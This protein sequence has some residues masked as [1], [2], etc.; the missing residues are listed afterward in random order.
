MFTRSCI[1]IWNNNGRIIGNYRLKNSRRNIRDFFYLPLLLL[2]FLIVNGESTVSI[3]KL[4][5][6]ERSIERLNIT[7]DNNATLNETSD[8]ANDMLIIIFKMRKIQM[9][10][11]AKDGNTQKFCIG[12]FCVSLLLFIIIIS[13]PSIIIL[14]L[15]IIFLSYVLR[16][17]QNYQIKS[18]K[19]YASRR[20]MQLQLNQQNSL[21]EIESAKF[22]KSNRDTES[23][24]SEIKPLRNMSEES[25]LSRSVMASTSSE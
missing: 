7:I 22:I 11:V 12:R 21:K 24:A 23:N 13:I 16:Q 3:R 14:I 19:L 17:K 8:K 18:N 15:F 2:F 4:I 9:I 10:I 20:L 5:E 6:I 1:L 25:E